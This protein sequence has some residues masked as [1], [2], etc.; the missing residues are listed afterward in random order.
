MPTHGL[1]SVFGVHVCSGR[2]QAFIQ[3]YGHKRRWDT[4]GGAGD[5]HTELQLCIYQVPPLSVSVC[6][7]Y[8]VHICCFTVYGVWDGDGD[9]TVIICF[10]VCFLFCSQPCVLSNAD[11]HEAEMETRNYR[12]KQVVEMYE[13]GEEEWRE[14]RA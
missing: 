5:D 12:R 1:Q 8:Y 4:G 6:F 3:D 13:D 2:R 7:P 10:T 11:L 9:F 14:E